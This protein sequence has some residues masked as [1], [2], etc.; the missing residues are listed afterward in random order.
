MKGVGRVLKISGRVRCK[1]GG[2]ETTLHALISRNVQYSAHNLERGVGEK[3]EG[4]REGLPARDVESRWERG[5]VG[6]VAP[7][8]VTPSSLKGV[9]VAF[10]PP[11]WKSSGWGGD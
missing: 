11:G 5:G 8:S 6:G 10:A 4:V 3:G 9:G 2:G 7:A 1:G